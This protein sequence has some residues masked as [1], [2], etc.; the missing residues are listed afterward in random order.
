MAYNFSKP[1][2]TA[3]GENL[4]LVRD[5]RVAVSCTIEAL[6]IFDHCHFQV[7]QQ[8]ANKPKKKL[9]LAKP[10]RSLSAKPWRDEDYG[11]LRKMRDRELL[12]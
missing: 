4:L 5:L 12:A 1:A 6:R 10:P 2:D 9:Q 8:A 7:A 11:N 3:N